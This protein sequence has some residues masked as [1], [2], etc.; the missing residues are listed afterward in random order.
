MPGKS[1]R[2]SL[3][4]S[5]GSV[6]LLAS[7]NREGTSLTLLRAGG[8][9]SLCATLRSSSP[10]S[11]ARS[12]LDGKSQRVVSEIAAVVQYLREEVLVGSVIHDDVGIVRVLD[13]A[14][15]SDYARMCG[16]KL[17]KSNFADM[18]LS[19]NW[20]LFLGTEEA[21][22]GMGSRIGAI[23]LLRTGQR[24]KRGLQADAWQGA[25]IRERS[26]GMGCGRERGG[27]IHLVA[28]LTPDNWTHSLQ[29]ECRSVS[30][31]C[32]LQLASVVIHLKI[33]H[34]EIRSTFYDSGVS[35]PFHFRHRTPRITSS[36]QTQAILRPIE[37]R[38]FWLKQITA[39]DF[40]AYQELSTIV[41]AL[42]TNVQSAVDHMCQQKFIDYACGCSKDSEFIQCA[43][44][45]GTYMKCWPV[46]LAGP[47]DR[48]LEV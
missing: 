35:G 46:P 7:V 47:S 16:G 5:R 23:G 12:R 39:C 8:R 41:A 3:L 37:R 44:R 2:P 34:D 28:Y 9:C 15:K 24:R 21:F 14:M 13:D 20:W 42:T 19:P 29:S 25:V 22:H 17:V 45:R 40:Y 33:A 10:S 38:L 4:S 11:Q 18:E 48:S 30:A 36:L 31:S 1:S 26:F 27:K 6:Q 43:A 32:V